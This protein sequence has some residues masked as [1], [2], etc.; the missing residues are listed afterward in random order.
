LSFGVAF[1]AHRVSPATRG[2]QRKLYQRI[3]VVTTM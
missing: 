3:P 1:F 2:R